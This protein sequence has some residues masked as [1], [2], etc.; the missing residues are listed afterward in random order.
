VRG[1]T[2]FNEPWVFMSFEET[3]E[4]L[5]SNV[6]SLGFDLNRLCASK[7]LLID[8]VHV[9]RSEIE[10]TGD[11]T[12]RASSSVWNMPLIQLGQKGLPSTRWNLFSQDCP[13]PSSFVR[14]FA[15]SFGGLK[16]KA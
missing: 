12:S 5:T 3:A 14:N 6:A 15:G 4:E 11:T 9:E 8:H 13:T 7:R 1:A 16:T 10:E 2:K